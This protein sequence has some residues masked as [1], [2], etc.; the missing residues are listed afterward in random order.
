MKESFRQKVLLV[1]D[2]TFTRALL[3]STLDNS[4][5]EVQSCASAVVALDVLKGFEPH[6]VITD[7]VPGLAPNGLDLL[8][9]VAQET[10]WIGMAIISSHSSPILATKDSNR[11]PEGTVFVAKSDIGNADDLVAIVQSTIERREFRACDTAKDSVLI[12]PTYGEVLRLI[13]AGL[14]NVAIANER[15]TSVRAAEAMVQRTF[16]ALG[17]RSD[18]NINARVMAVRMWHQGKVKIL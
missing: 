17:I 14:S 8:E 10:P 13:A 6:A 18:A 11:I 15:G 5:I 4:G 3:S 12:S 16:L 2:D 7:L 1:E 9:L